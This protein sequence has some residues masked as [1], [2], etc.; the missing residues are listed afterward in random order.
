MVRQSGFGVSASALFRLSPGSRSSH[1]AARTARPRRRSTKSGWPIPILPNMVG[2]A[3]RLIL[4]PL[5]A[6]GRIGQHGGR[7][8][9]WAPPTPTTPSTTRP[10]WSLG[11]RET[12]SARGPLWPA[13]VR[14]GRERAHGVGS[15]R[16]FRAGAS[17]AA[18]AILDFGARAGGPRRQRRCTKG[19]GPCC[20]AS[21]SGNERLLP[22]L[23]LPGEP[24]RHGSG[25]AGPRGP[26][27]GGGG[28]SRRGRCR[29]GQLLHR[30][31][32]E[33]DQ[34]A[35]LR[36]PAGAPAPTVGRSRPSSW[37]APRRATTARCAPCLPYGPW[38][39]APTRRRCS[40]RSGSPRRAWTRC[41][42]ASARTTAAGSRSRTV[43]T[44]TAASARP[45]SPAAPTGR[46]PSRN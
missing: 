22:Y 10:A 33:R 21:A 15:G 35:A 32:G 18:M 39:R 11:R 43:A 14:P 19:S 38:S 44:S 45:R 31:R 46:A 34:A 16:R 12:G 5:I 3:V 7:G 29:G 8:R 42:G 2:G 26:R 20:S 41:C 9:A 40:R 37:A 25:A 23:R 1:S 24:V 13:A 28:R 4:G 6:R 36:A 27:G 17:R 30:H